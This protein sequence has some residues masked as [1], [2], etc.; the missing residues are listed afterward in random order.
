MLRNFDSMLKKTLS[1]KYNRKYSFKNIEKIMKAWNWT[2]HEDVW[3][4]HECF[5]I[6]NALIKYIQQN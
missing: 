6:M 2:W 1:R 3:W 4:Y 5:N